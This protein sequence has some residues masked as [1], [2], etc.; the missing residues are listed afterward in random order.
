M[1]TSSLEQRVINAFA[2]GAMKD[3]SALSVDS[4]I[5]EIGID[6]SDLICMI[7]EIEDEFGIE[8][9]EGFENNEFVTLGDIAKAVQDYVD[10]NNID[11]GE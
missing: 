3:A 10:E 5:E 7:F 4:V 6:S 11:I 8:I 2:K 9:P 1:T